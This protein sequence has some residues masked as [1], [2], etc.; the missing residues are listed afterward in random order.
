MPDKPSARGGPPRK[1]PTH[2]PT[3]VTERVGLFDR[4]AT[5]SEQF[6]SRAGFFITCLLAV[7]LW[8]PAY[9]VVNS[10]DTWQLIINTISSIVTLLL[11]A[12]LQNTQTRSDQ[13]TQDKLNAIAQGLAELMDSM[14]TVHDQD[15]LQSAVAEL[16][17]AVGIERV[18][19]A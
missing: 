5:H 18:E 1:P 19:S 12:L 9:F 16:R 13:A 3:D 17:A 14:A 2:M 10:L 6:A 8:G 4:F 15:G 7:V 11:V